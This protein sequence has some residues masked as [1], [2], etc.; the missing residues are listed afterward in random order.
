MLQK[1]AQPA[2]APTLIEDLN[3]RQLRGL[4]AA[5][6]ISHK[7]YAQACGLSYSLVSHI[8]TGR[9]PG[10]LAKIKLE[11]GLARLGLDVEAHRAG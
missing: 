10:E 8:L 6:R 11:R 7:R 2:G 3:F 9:A 5:Q 4:L 1:I